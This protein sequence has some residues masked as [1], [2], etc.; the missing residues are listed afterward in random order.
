MSINSVKV[1]ELKNGQLIITL[2]KGIANFKKW[3]KGTKLV[4][5]ED[6]STG[7]VILKEDI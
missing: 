4:F 5:V 1:Q 3:A 6:H 7:N 2:P